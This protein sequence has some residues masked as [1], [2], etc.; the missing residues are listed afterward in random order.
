MSPGSQIV[1]VLQAR[2]SS[3]RLPGKVLMPLLG[4]PMLFRQIERVR[5]SRLIDRLIVATSQDVS[6]DRLAEM[7]RE[8]QIDCFRGDLNDVLDRFYR[9]AAPHAPLHVVRLTGDCPLADPELIDKVIGFHLEGGFDYSSNTIRP[10][11]PDGL[12]VEICRFAVLEQAWMEANLPSQREHVTPFMYQQPE[13]FRLGGFTNVSDLSRLRWTVDEADDFELVAMIYDAL[14][15]HNPGFTTAEI[16]AYLD[17][18]PELVMINT[19]H[20]RNEG[21][22]A[23]QLKDAPSSINERTSA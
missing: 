9:A 12:D 23:S 11:F 15:P 10:T 16:V 5:R 1:V 2:F 4:E 18:N 19:G 6:D 14:Y 21:Y 22:E 17:A 8:R 7:C 3:A 20:K 13:R